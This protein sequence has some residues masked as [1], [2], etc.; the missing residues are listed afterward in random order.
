MS[1]VPMKD[2]DILE[3]K[4]VKSNAVEKQFH[5]LFGNSFSLL[6]DPIP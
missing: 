2:E 6:F 1:G 5:P 3:E 4:P